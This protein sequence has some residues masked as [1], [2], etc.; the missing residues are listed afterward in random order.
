VFP[1][2]SFYVFRSPTKKELAL[3]DRVVYG[4]KKNLN[5]GQISLLG[6][7]ETA[8]ELAVQLAARL[9]ASTTALLDT[10]NINGQNTRGFANYRSSKLSVTLNK[11]TPT[12]AS[13][14]PSQTKRLLIRIAPRAH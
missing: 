2:S 14:I 6:S 3:Q 7:A 11:R 5:E 12:T 9:A 1:Y 8:A 13:S 4:R 10:R